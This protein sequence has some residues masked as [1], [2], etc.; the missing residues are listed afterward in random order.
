M[1]CDKHY[2]DRDLCRTG[3]AMVLVTPGTGV[4]EVDRELTAITKQR[5]M[6]NAIG[7]DFVSLTRAPLHVAPLFVYKPSP[8]GRDIL[9]RKHPFAR[10]DT[11]RLATE[12]EVYD[13]RSSEKAAAATLPVYNIPHW[14]HLS[15]PYHISRKSPVRLD[16]PGSI[17]SYSHIEDSHVTSPS[18]FSS[19]TGTALHQVTP[20]TTTQ[21]HF[22]PLPFNRMYDPSEPSRSGFPTALVA[23]LQRDRSN[24]THPV[25]NRSTLSPWYPLIKDIFGALGQ[26]RS[27]QPMELLAFD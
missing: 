5:M 4:F 7:C 9:D 12:V 22:E 6:D 21:E 26:R 24:T 17:S 15:F 25:P 3:Q 20:A 16:T 13:Q 18:R 1:P 2:M 8:S 10:V 14:I 23:H 19:S 11:Y 27:S